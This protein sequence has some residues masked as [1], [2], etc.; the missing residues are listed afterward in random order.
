[1]SKLSLKKDFED[2]AK[3]PSKDLNNNFLVIEECVNNTE[4]APSAYE[5][6][7]EKGFEGT[8]EEWLNHLIGPEGEQGVEGKKG[9]PGATGGYALL[10]VPYLGNIEGYD[11][12]LE[13]YDLQKTNLEITTL[14]KDNIDYLNFNIKDMSKLDLNLKVLC[15]SENV[16]S[17]TANVID[18]NVDVYNEDMTKVLKT[19]VYHH[20]LTKVMEHSLF[21]DT[22]KVFDTFVA[23]FSVDISSLNNFNVVIKAN[24]LK[25]EDGN[26]SIG[27][28]MLSSATCFIEMFA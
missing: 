28:I 5:L 18:F 8:E 7:K 17:N 15:F 24:V 26:A 10:Y 27:S 11:N 13:N 21:D 2:G 12:P 6:A 19:Y 4:K 14:T 16:D 9:K 20:E 25:Y 3:L 1:M 22:K 23:N